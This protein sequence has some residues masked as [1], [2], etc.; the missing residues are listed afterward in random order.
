MG[1]A[2]L[3]AAGPF[4]GLFFN[5]FFQIFLFRTFLKKNLL[6]SI[7]F[8]FCSGGA[9]LLCLKS[10]WGDKAGTILADTA[11]YILLSYGYFHFLNL[12]ETARR[13]RILCELKEASPDGL[14]QAQILERYNAQEILDRRLER[15]VKN[16]QVICR[17]GRYYI[18]KPIMLIA[19]KTTSVFKRMLLGRRPKNG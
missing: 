13:I 6:K 12:T 2:V 5:V 11:T 7:I 3:S 8:G 18:G 4:L 19:A 16:G 10:A 17:D 15:L 14:T 1:I 9:C